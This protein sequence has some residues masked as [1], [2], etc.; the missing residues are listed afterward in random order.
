MLHTIALHVEISTAQF[1]SNFPLF[2]CL[3]SFCALSDAFQ[4]FLSVEFKFVLKSWSSNSC[5]ISEPTDIPSFILAS[6]IL[7]N[8]CLK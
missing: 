5:L 3:E 2:H 4:A 1:H 7:K 6:F 8:S